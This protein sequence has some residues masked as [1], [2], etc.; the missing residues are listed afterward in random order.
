V[1]AGSMGANGQ[2]D[3]LSGISVSSS[4]NAKTV[5]W[6]FNTTTCN[7][8]VLTTQTSYNAFGWI[9]NRGPSA[10]FCGQGGVGFESGGAAYMTVN[11]AVAE[12]VGLEAELANAGDYIVMETETFREYPN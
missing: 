12:T 8:I 2:I 9:T 6:L 3:M 4:A 7:A 10:Q 11:T 5:D 1:T